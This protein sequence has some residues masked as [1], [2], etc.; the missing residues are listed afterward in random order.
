MRQTCAKAL[1]KTPVTRQNQ[2]TPSH[3][4]S[5]CRQQ[6]GKES[7][8]QQRR[9]NR[10]VLVLALVASMLSGMAQLSGGVGAQSATPVPGAQT[11]QIQVDNLSP[12]GYA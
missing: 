4:G 12:P 8:V 9:H 2:S 1:V 10:V 7:P 6:A 3:A 5:A 11:W